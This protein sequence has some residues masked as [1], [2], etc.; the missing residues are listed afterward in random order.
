M[1]KK[2]IASLLLA[3]SSILPFTIAQYVQRTDY[4]S[5]YDSGSSFTTIVNR[6]RTLSRKI[7]N[8]R[9]AYLARKA[10]YKAGVR[11]CQEE[12]NDYGLSS[13]RGT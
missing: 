7:G 2:A 5:K 9:G 13:I 1:L 3:S 4:C 11:G 10:A 12:F 6:E 8:L